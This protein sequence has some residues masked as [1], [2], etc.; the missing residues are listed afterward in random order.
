MQ[1]SLLAEAWRGE[2]GPKP[3]GHHCCRKDLP[4]S[5]MPGRRHKTEKTEPDRKLSPGFKPRQVSCELLGYAGCGRPTL[6]SPGTDP[7]ASGACAAERCVPHPQ[8]V[9]RGQV[10]PA[11]WA[12]GA[13]GLSVQTAL[14][15]PW[16]SRPPE[17]CLDHTRGF[18]RRAG[19][20]ASS[21]TRDTADGS[22]ADSRG[23]LVA[24]VA[25]GRSVAGALSGGTL[26]HG[27]PHPLLRPGHLCR[28][29]P[30]RVALSCLFPPVA[31]ALSCPSLG[32]GPSSCLDVVAPCL[33]PASRP[34]LSIPRAGGAS[35]KGPSESFLPPLQPP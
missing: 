7:A 28:E 11:V 12:A 27:P 31:R 3:R 21:P 2:L 33:H 30:G 32:P 16:A 8:Q 22:T 5:R 34:G 26:A 15:A 6:A 24:L 14:G 1:S 4:P 18:P 10:R 23:S 17:W 19:A 13:A 29:Q 35:G 9:G 25:S 20:K